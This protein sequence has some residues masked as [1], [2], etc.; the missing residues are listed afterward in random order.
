[1]AVKAGLLSLANQFL[2]NFTQFLLVK[3]LT[4]FSLRTKFHICHEL[5]DIGEIR[6]IRRAEKSF[7]KYRATA[8]IL[9]KKKKSFSSSCLKGVRAGVEPN[10]C[11]ATMGNE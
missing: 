5:R 6:E 7:I 11:S 1:M 4:K 3:S 8:H 9:K 10:H 2:E